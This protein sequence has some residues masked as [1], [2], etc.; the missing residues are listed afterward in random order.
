MRAALLT[1]SI[2]ADGPGVGAG[3]DGAGADV[4]PIGTLYDPWNDAP[5]PG[6]E[7]S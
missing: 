5:G 7:A 3:A 4:D 2:L 6:T 1:S